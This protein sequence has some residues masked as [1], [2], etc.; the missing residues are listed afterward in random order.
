MAKM[1]PKAYSRFIAYHCTRLAVDAGQKE[2]ASA[3]GKGVF[4][5]GAPTGKTVAVFFLVV[6]LALEC[7]EVCMTLW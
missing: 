7:E 2:I 5:K 1:T 4:F 3:A 6:L